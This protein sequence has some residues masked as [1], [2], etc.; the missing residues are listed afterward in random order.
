MYKGP[1]EKSTWYTVSYMCYRYI[2]S[3]IINSSYPSISRPIEQRNPDLIRGAIYLQ[4][5]SIANSFIDKVK[6]RWTLVI[7]SLV[8]V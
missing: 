5:N 2:N 4:K 1:G 7:T 6:W 8:A 3:L